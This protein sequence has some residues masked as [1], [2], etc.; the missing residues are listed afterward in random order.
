W[1]FRGA[2]G[3]AGQRG[4]LSD[5]SEYPGGEGTGHHLEMRRPGAGWVSA[6]H[7]S[8]A[9]SFGAPVFGRLAGRWRSTA[10]RRLAALASAAT[11]LGVAGGQLG[12]P[13]GVVARFRRRARRRRV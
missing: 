6:G 12:P 13:R 1:S 3:D 5:A 11:G 10:E 7:G 9:D 8:R 4:P 2:R